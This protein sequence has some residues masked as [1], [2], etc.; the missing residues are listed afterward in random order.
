MNGERGVGR[1]WD[2][3]MSVNMQLSVKNEQMGGSEE[4]GRKEHL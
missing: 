3:C 4:Q 1:D 2:E